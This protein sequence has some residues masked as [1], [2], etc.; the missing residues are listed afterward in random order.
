MSR[1]G[2]CYDNAHMESF[3]ASLK[4]ELGGA[5]R[6]AADA[7][8]KVRSYIHFYNHERRHSSLRYSSPVAYE[9]LAI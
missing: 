7:I 1:R 8:G 2:N 9:R 5:F 3:F 4:L 6:S